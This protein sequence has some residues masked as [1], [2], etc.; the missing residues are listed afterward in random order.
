MES[1]RH[2]LDRSL[3]S[4][5]SHHTEIRFPSSPSLQGS[6]GNSKLDVPG[7]ID[8]NAVRLPK[9]F[10]DGPDDAVQAE[11]SGVIMPSDPPAS[12]DFR[13][14]GEK[15]GFNGSIAMVGIDVDQVE[16]SIRKS[17]GGLRTLILDHR[18]VR[19]SLDN[20]FERRDGAFVASPIINCNHLLSEQCEKF[21]TNSTKAT[22][23]GDTF[24]RR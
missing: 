6:H 8:E 9:H 19:A 13:A 5:G 3:V 14:P 22:D 17:Q 12:A 7:S 2:F 15:V 21:G 20:A 18:N 24:E 16:V 4:A 11:G 23:F 1:E 10:V